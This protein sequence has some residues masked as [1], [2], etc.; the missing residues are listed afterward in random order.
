MPANAPAASSRTVAKAP[1]VNVPNSRRVYISPPRL[2]VAQPFRA[3]RG[4]SR[5]EGL[6]YQRPRPCDGS[7]IQTECVQRVAGGGQ[8]VLLS[9]HHV[10]LGCIRN[11]ADLRMPQEL[12]V[13]RVECDEIA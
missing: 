5:P 9:V 2:D 6:R 8:D 7:S 11:L 10:G 4:R 1:S 3:A 13:R 12:A